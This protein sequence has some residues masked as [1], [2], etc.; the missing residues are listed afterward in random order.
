MKRI[1]RLMV[2]LLLVSFGYV[3]GTSQLSGF[4]QALLAQL[5]QS[6]LQLADLYNRVSPSVVSINIA[7]RSG[8][9]FVEVSGGSG[10]VIDSNGHIVTNY[11]VVEGADRDTRIEVNFIDGT[12][13]EAEI[14]GVDPDSDLAVIRV[15]LPRER[16]FPVSLG[17]SNNLVIGQTTVALGS[18]FGQRW[19]MTTGIVSALERTIQGLSQ[20]QIGAVIQTDAAIN[21]G[22][23]GGPLFNLQGEVIGVNSQISS[24][25]RVNSGIGYAVPSNL[26]KRVAK[27]LIEEQRVRY[28]FLG[29]SGDDITLDL[30]NE[31]NL[32]DNTR[33]V[34]I[35]DLGRGRNTSP[36]AQSGLEINDIIIAVDDRPIN[37]FGEL[38]A[39][40]SIE[41]EP[42]DTVTIRVL[43]EGDPLEF[44]VILGER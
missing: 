26:V 7:I 15:D 14:V 8:R 43:R 22:N 27:A 5:T 40:L 42:G 1:K 35:A 20:Y 12:I 6:E 37:N 41:T 34:V 25:E 30:I 29:I 4:A 21:P 38:I 36:A 19:T 11:H 23:S 44:E 17:D 10:F 2:M 31:L 24:L 39:Y 13:I 3:L 18:P 33:G 9:D 16:L 32:A 28:S